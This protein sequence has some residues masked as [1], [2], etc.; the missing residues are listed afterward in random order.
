MPIV[1]LKPHDPR[2]GQRLRSLIDGADDGKRYTEGG[3]YEVTEQ[4]AAHLAEYMQNGERVA[5]DERVH[6]LVRAFDIWPDRASAQ[7]ALEE[8]G[9]GQLLQPSIKQVLIAPDRDAAEIPKLAPAAETQIAALTSR[10][11]TR[12]F[13]GPAPAG[14]KSVPV[15][16]AAPGEPEP[17]DDATFFDKDKP[18]PGA[19]PPT[20]LERRNAAAARAATRAKAATG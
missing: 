12:T 7:A 13:R 11:E 18:T 20:A 19:R 16:K 1:R 15:A 14:P 10:G 5:A 3:L 8:E 4:V 2:K 6:G 17:A 9:R